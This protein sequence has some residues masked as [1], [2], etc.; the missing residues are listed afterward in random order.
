MNPRDLLLVRATATGRVV[1][2]KAFLKGEVVDASRIL[3]GFMT[4][5]LPNVMTDIHFLCLSQDPNTEIVL[6]VPNTFTTANLVVAYDGEEFRVICGRFL[7][8]G[9][10]NVFAAEFGKNY[11]VLVH[12]ETELTDFRDRLRDHLQE[13]YQCAVPETQIDPLVLP[14]Y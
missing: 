8:R 14:D 2:Q 6:G 7:A 13:T 5:T 10:W 11:D 12:I 1:D 3:R 4:T 9:T